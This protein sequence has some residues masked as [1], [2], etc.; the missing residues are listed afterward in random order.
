MENANFDKNNNDGKTEKTRLDNTR[1][2][3]SSAVNRLVG[4]QQEGSGTYCTIEA[5]NTAGS[6]RSN[7]E[8]EEL[9]ELESRGINPYWDKAAFLKELKTQS[10]QNGVWLDKSYLDGKS[11]LHDQKAT[12]TSENDMY[13]NA[14]GK[15]VTKINNLSYVKGSEHCHNL[16]AT[17]DRLAAHNTLF[18]QLAYTI[19]G[20]VENKNG[21]P[22]LVLEQP[23][24]KDVERNAAKEEIDKYLADKGFKLSGTRTWS[25]GHEVWSNGRF[26]LFDT[27]PANV[28]KGNDGS[29]YIVD[30]F[31]HSVEYLQAEN[32]QDSPM[33]KEVKTPL[34]KVL[35]GRSEKKDQEKQEDPNWKFG[36]E[37]QQEEPKKESNYGKDNKIFT[38]DAAAAARER[39]RQRRNNI[40]SGV[41]FSAM[42]DI[43]ILAGYHI[44]SGA[45]KFSDFVKRMVEDIGEEY[46]PYLKGGL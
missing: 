24:V 43:A 4:E 13:L 33:P 5:S 30:A 16:N 11:L 3:V 15:S 25:N 8:V 6:I 21:Y 38:E 44:E 17:I 20:F 45:R 41:D 37:K 46:K 32:K 39:L 35:E 18:P 42:Q 14:D 2:M 29:L 12:G 23:F 22:S 7:Y 1:T 40:N 31:P 28:L 36:G 10:Q 9:E 34:E 27:R 19:K 26:E